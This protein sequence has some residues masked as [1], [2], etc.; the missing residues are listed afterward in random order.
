MNT[1]DLHAYDREN[2][3]EIKPLGLRIFQE[4]EYG[5]DENEGDEETE[6]VKIWMP[7][8]VKLYSHHNIPT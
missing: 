8:S 1:R 7:K 6:D 3:E 2:Y 5:A 4:A